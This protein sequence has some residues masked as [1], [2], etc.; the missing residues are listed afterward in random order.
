MHDDVD[1]VGV[2]NMLRIKVSP[3]IKTYAVD[4]DGP[5]DVDRANGSSRELP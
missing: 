3:R 2:G 1:V 4:L 5:R